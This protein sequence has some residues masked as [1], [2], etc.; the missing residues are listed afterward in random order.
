MEVKVSLASSSRENGCF[1]NW[2]QLLAFSIV[3]LKQLGF[4]LAR[5]KL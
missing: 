4:A 3:E 5:E 2:I 1:Y